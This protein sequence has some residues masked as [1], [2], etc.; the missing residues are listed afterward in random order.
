MIPG[1]H[2]LDLYR[3]DTGR[4]QFK[5]WSDTAKTDPVDLTGCTVTAMIRD[6]IPSSTFQME[7]DCVLTTPN[8]IDM[9]LTA[10]ASRDLPATGV[11][12]IQITWANGDISTILKGT[13]KV[14][15]DVTFVGT[16]AMTR[17]LTAVP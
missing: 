6:K 13:V 10:L 8:I 11:W 7:M 16:T 14:T 3:G 1:D 12:D 4:W 15:N 17:R 9:E 5:L 2:N